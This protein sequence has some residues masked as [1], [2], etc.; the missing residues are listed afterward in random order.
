V[1]IAT[2]NVNS[3]SARVPRLVEWLGAVG[4]DV[5][6]L[7]ETK[8]ADGDFPSDAVA[9]L[10]YEVAA[11]GLG[12][13]N[14]VAVL[15]RVGLAEVVKGLAGGPGF[16]Q[17]EARAIGATCAGVR[18]WSVYVPHGREPDHPHYAYKLEWL[19]ALR[20]VV[21][22]ELSD[23]RPLAVCGDFNVAPTDADVWDPA[24]FAQ[25]THVTPA[26]RQALAALRAL[27][28]ADVVPRPLKYDQPF[29]Y[30]D[31]RAGMF[32]KNFGMRIDLVYANQP[33]AAA[34][35]DAY[36]DRETRK[37]KGPSDHAP[38]VV[39]VAVGDLVRP[40][41]GDVL[42]RA[43]E[44]LGLPE[45]A[46]AGAPVAPPRMVGTPEGAARG[47]PAGTEAVSSPDVDRG[48]K[49]MFLAKDSAV[50]PDISDPPEFSPMLA[51][52][53]HQPFDDPGWRFEPKLDGVRTLAY[54][55]PAA[56]R[57][58]SPTG[59]DHTARY[60][61][62][63]GLAHHVKVASA[64]IDGEIIVCDEAGRPS[65]ELLQR[66]V[67]LTS[68]GDIERV[69][70]E[71]PVKLFAF[72][73]LWL[74]G[75]D[76]TGM[77]LEERRRRLEQTVTEGDPIG[78]TYFLDGE[79]RRLLEASRGLGLDGVVAKRLGSPYLPGRSSE[80]RTLKALSGPLLAVDGPS[81]LYRAFF[82]LPKTIT[83]PA[84][85][86]V[87]ALLGAANLILAAVEA[88]GP[89]VVVVCFGAEAAHYRVELYPAYH[90]D[91]P[92]M[93]AELESQWADAP[94]FFGAFGWDVIGHDTLEADDLLGSLAAVEADAGGRAL[95]FTGDRDMFQ[96]VAERV[97]VL[98]PTGAGKAPNSS[99]PTGCGAA[100]ASNPTRSP[101]S[102]PCGATPPTASPAPGASAR[103]RRGTCS[104]STAPS[105]APSPGREATPVAWPPPWPTT[106]T[107]CAPSPRSPG[108]VAS[109]WPAR[110]TGPPTSP[111]RRRPPGPGG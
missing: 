18:L 105:R 48:L 55:S 71:V 42:R 78:L 98:F 108:C 67:N 44:G 93:P 97:A 53:G 64:V 41:P 59:G 8:C 24:E 43:G 3:V 65:S 83:G 39:D 70:H 58:V 14:G 9:A 26:E 101:T 2:W 12:R 27:G 28:L 63:G 74:D 35:R 21:A 15:S 25:A 86:A 91:R 11:F 73:L 84:G 68:P 7:Q 94:A 36:V 61:D 30:W 5:V 52:G 110:P 111:A 69:R 20:E 57:L 76:V 106:P 62:L 45:P 51:E 100:T 34:V 92:P 79:G 80:W 23:D 31:Y 104:A 90:A 75:V 22:R 85:Q 82:A 17:P 46:A 72:D 32:H 96:C 103:K 19:A 16:P 99:T 88:H 6:C 37:G 81:L 13:W 50:P 56:T 29:T 87:N 47:G 60:P 89:R 40:V 10:G 49:E 95:L 54:V 4:P 77:P 109:T 38:V 33:F 102:S 1:R 107:S 66:R